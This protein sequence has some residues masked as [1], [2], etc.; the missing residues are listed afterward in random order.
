MNLV[1]ASQCRNCGFKSG[2]GYLWWWWWWVAVHEGYHPLA[3]YA[4]VF[5]FLSYCVRIM[6]ICSASCIQ[7]FNVKKEVH[8]PPGQPVLHVQDIDE[9]KPLIAAPISLLEVFEVS[10]VCESE[11]ML[12]LIRRQDG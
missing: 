8:G 10:L 7:S 3:T 5:P 9:V 12:L 2:L 6:S 1:Q 4:Q 11:G